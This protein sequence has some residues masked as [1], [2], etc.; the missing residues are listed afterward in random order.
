MSAG[1]GNTLRL[2]DPQQV[3]CLGLQKG[4]AASV[5]SMAFSP[6]DST[7]LVTCDQGWSIRLWGIGEPPV[8]PAK[9]GGRG[10]V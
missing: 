5:R 9:V 7:L 6:T 10:V 2:W 4:A 8:K 1:Q 3:K